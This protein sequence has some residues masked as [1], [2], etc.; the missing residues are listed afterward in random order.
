MPEKESKDSSLE[1][2]RVV[3][4]GR[5][6]AMTQRDAKARLRGRGA[7][8]VDRPGP[9]VDWIVLGEEGIPLLSEVA[10]EAAIEETFSPEIQE[11]IAAGRT[12]VFSEAEL[13]KK[14]GLTEFLPDEDHFYT[15]AHVGPPA[16][17]PPFGYPPMASTRA[18]CPGPRGPPLGLLRLSG[19]GH[20]PATESTAL[21]RGLSGGDRKETRDV[22]PVICPASN[23]RWPN[24]PSW[25]KGAIF[26]CAKEID[27]SSRAANSGS[28]S[29]PPNR[30]NSTIV[31]RS[32]PNRAKRLHR[33]LPN[34]SI[35]LRRK[36]GPLLRK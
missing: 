27:W 28:I 21:G 19:S 32:Y 30:R 13:W 6:A 18:D 16:G 15:P 1:A 17:S 10:G 4:I 26:S 8:V 36:T 9:T 25:S 2:V 12:S 31:H 3:L 20:R 29:T 14:L 7:V 11:A 35:R 23:V 24:W 5:F 33:R 22:F 34:R